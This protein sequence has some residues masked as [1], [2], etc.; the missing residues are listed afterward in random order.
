MSSSI[1]NI[2]PELSVR[3]MRFAANTMKGERYERNEDAFLALPEW[4]VFAVADGMG[5]HN[6]GA[7]AS[8]MTV[9]HIV[10]RL[11]DYRGDLS[12]D[13][14]LGVISDANEAVFSKAQSTSDLRGM[15]TTLS[16]L[17]FSDS[18]VMIYHVGDSRV[19]RHHDFRATQLTCDHT[20]GT[21]DLGLLK[22]GH[23]SQRG[24]TRAIGVRQDVNIDVTRYQHEPGAEYLIVSDGITDMLA[25]Y[26]I[27]NVVSDVSLSML[28]RVDKLISLANQSGGTDD[29]TAILLA[30]QDE[31][32]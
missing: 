26:K 13:F 5:G 1:R 4:N 6:G 10:D 2:V 21:K 12:K 30:P 23:E 15:G 8:N 11:S 27:G 22:D 16:L 31:R 7:V 17:H 9:T 3:S 32:M 18:E 25:N 28:K 19:Y 24:I 14:L 20:P 29:K